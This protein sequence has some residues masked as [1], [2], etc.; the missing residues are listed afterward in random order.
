M[1]ETL[2]DVFDQEMLPVLEVRVLD[3][4]KKNSF[5]VRRLTNFPIAESLQDMKTALQKFMP[6]ITHVDNLQIGYILDRN[7]KFTIETNCEL[8]DA[9]QHFK[10]DNQMWLDPSPAKAAS[11]RKESAK[12]I[13][14]VYSSCAYI[15]YII[16]Q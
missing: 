4:T 5:R 9:W 11:K 1:A 16:R 12:N 2:D 8:S 3:I 7:K 6:D 10:N 13:S 14:G 15:S